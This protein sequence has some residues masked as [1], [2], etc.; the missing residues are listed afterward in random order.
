MAIYNG[1][2]FLPE[3]IESVLSQLEPQ[4]ELIVID[5]AST[6]NSSSLFSMLSSK[7]IRLFTN[8]SNIG[9]VG[10]FQRGLELARHEL[11]FLCDQD[12]IWLPGKRTAYVTAFEKT[13]KAVIVISDTEVID[14]EGKLMHP[15]FMTSRGGFNGGVLATLWRNRYLGC[16]MALRRSVLQNALPIPSRVPMHDMWLGMIGRI[17]GDVIYLSTPY[18]RYRRHTANASPS[19]RQSWPQMLRWRF[20]LLTALVYR[21]LSIKLGTHKFNS[22]HAER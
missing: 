1:R 21:I 15:S 8:T 19:T 9:V 7:Q 3:Q 11:I 5:D 18:L 4:D 10:S 22:S 14:Q 16:A 20:A 6:D 2:K 12:D 17:K 13:P